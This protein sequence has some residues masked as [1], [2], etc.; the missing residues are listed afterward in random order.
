MVLMIYLASPYSHPDTLIMK[1]RFLLAEQAT[2]ILTI[3]GQHVYS[4]IVHYHEI[5]RKFTLQ[6]DFAFWKFINF[7]MIR[8]ADAFYILN[9]DGWETSKGVAAEKAFAQEC[10]LTISA[11]NPEGVVSPWLA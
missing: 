7:D 9:I 5:A 6:T 11:V 3:A 8:K 1:T 2:A 10:G 4:P